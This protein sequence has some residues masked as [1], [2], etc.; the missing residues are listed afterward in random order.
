MLK[1]IKKKRNSK[2]WEKSS[3]YLIYLKAQAKIPLAQIICQ[4]DM[5]YRQLLHH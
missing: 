5:K 2:D 1:Y 3:S 4:T